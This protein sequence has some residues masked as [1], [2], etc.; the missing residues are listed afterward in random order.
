MRHPGRR[1]QGRRHRRRLSW[2]QAHVGRFCA[3]DE[4]TNSA[5]ATDPAAWEAEEGRMRTRP[6]RPK[7]RT[8]MPRLQRMGSGGRARRVRE[9]ELPCEQRRDRRR[10]RC[11]LKHASHSVH[12]R[13]LTFDMSG[14]RQQAAQRQECA[15][16]V[17]RP[18]VGCPL[19]GRVRCRA[20]RRGTGYS[21]TRY[22]TGKLLPPARPEGRLQRSRPLG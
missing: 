21:H 16:A 22:L 19:D 4:G 12:P 18:A 2:A 3:S 20:H 1:E 15:A 14:S 8:R 9:T 10:A 17:A 11:I 6:V 7:S 13:G 5:S